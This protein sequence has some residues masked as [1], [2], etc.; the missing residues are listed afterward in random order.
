M[1]LLVLYQ[2]I[3]APRLGAHC[4]FYPSCSEY[5][6]QAISLRGATAG[7]FLAFKRLIRCNQLFKGGFD[8]VPE[9]VSRET[10]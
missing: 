7:L 4:R 3:V 2:K 5:A 9:Y 1:Y 10:I 8:P 6:Y